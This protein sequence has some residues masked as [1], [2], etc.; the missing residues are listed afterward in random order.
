ML[1][2]GFVGTGVFVVVTAGNGV[3]VAVCV[4]VDVLVEVEVF[5]GVAVGRGVLVAV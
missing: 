5:W 4:G 3:F 2:G 1:V